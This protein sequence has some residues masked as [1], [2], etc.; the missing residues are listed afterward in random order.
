MHKKQIQKLEIETEQT[1]QGKQLAHLEGFVQGH[2]EKAQCGGKTFLFCPII[3][4][5][6]YMGIF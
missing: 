5:R 2:A 3:L 6:F 1:S 4:F